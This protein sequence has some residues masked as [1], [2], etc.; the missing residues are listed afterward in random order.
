MKTPFLDL[1]ASYHELKS[2][3]DSAIHKVLES[4]HYILGDEVESFER[5]FAVY[6]DS[7]YTVGVANGLDALFLSLLALGVGPGDEVIVP[8][9]TFVATWLAV[10][11]CGAVPV[12]VEPDSLTFNINANRIEA[13]ITQKTKVI[14]PVHLYG[15]PADMTKILA[16]AEKHGLKVIEDA[17]QA[18]GAK[19]NGKP[20]GGHG[21]AV[22]WSFYPGK[23]L[24]AF[25]DGGAITTN[26][27]AL[28]E[29]LRS[30]RNYGSS[31]KYVNDFKGLNSRLDPIQAATLSVKL[32][33]LGE[34]NKRR[35]DIA[36]TYL[37]DIDNDLVILPSVADNEEASWHLFVIQCKERD[38]MQRHLE[39]NGIGSLIHYP[40]APH[41]QR[42][43]E[44]LGY[45][46]GAFPIA[47]KLQQ[48]VLSI[49]IGPQLSSEHVNGIVSAVNCFKLL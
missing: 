35:R 15:R 39:C 24:G 41:L 25:G 19:Y 45:K 28:A 31:Q 8:S 10:S 17:A 36:I 5:E 11:R 23:N 30:L 26:N 32:K 29:K 42:A 27:K 13:A 9:N 48:T 22:A 20:I 38:K 44:D 14:M 21:D 37:G 49:P 3:I 2:E 18:Q 34:W 7:N 16:I 4:G 40:I 46:E 1:R 47:E 33:Y 43:Y 12:P 6:C